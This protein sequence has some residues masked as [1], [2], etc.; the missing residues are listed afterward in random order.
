MN[1]AYPPVLFLIIAFALLIF[2]VGAKELKRP[3][4]HP[5]RVVVKYILSFLAG[6]LCIAALAGPYEEAEKEVRTIGSGKCVFLF[7]ESWSMSAKGSES[8]QTRLQR[9]R[10]MAL[11]LNNNLQGCEKAVY[12]FSSKV[13]SHSDFSKDTNYIE[14]AV[15]H[16]VKIEAIGGRGSDLATGIEGALF[17]FRHTSSDVQK[18]VFLWSDGGEELKPYDLEKLQEHLLKAKE[19]RIRVVAVG[20]GE[21]EGVFLGTSYYGEAITSMLNEESLR[22]I[23]AQT[24]GVYFSEEEWRAGMT[25]SGT[26]LSNSVDLAVRKEPEKGGKSLVGFFLIPAFLAGLALFARFR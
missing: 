21:K 17:A 22:F 23:A 25:S 5:R 18:T 13:G 14:R 19:K 2:L 9:S 3:R 26:F 7:D 15:K 11:E 20:V 4:F 24:D 8:G 10:A 16:L 12:G 1:I 6:S